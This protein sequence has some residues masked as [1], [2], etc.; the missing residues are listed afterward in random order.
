MRKKPSL[1]Y[2]NSRLVLVIDAGTTNVKV[3]LFDET[4]AVIEK[5]TKKISKKFPAK[6]RV[7]QDPEEI[8]AIVCRLL[9]KIFRKHKEKADKILGVGITNQRETI[10]A[11]DKKTGRAIY[12]A[13][14]WED[15]RGKD[16]L[17]GIRKKI[18]SLKMKSLTGLDIIPY[19]SASKIKWLLENVPRAG[20]LLQENRLACGTMDSWILFKLTGKTSYFT[21][22]TNA[23][24]TMLFNIKTLKWDQE[25]LN[26]F[27]VS[28]GILPDAKP[29]FFPFGKISKN[30]L[31]KELPILAAIGDQQASLY[32]AG[33]SPG[34]T[35]ITYGTGAFILENIG[36]KF[37]TK[38]NLFT[39]LAA[40]PGGRPAFAL[41]GKVS[42]CGAL[43]SPVL[44]N[45]EKKKAAIKKITKQVDRLLKKF[46]KR[47]KKIIIDG[48]VSQADETLEE[49]AKISKVRLERQKNFEGT[50][51]GTAKL[52]FDSLGRIS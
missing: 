10:V 7:E 9:K 12:P 2:S 52:I 26:I 18:S 16:I 21:D 40:G 39:T 25:L 27:G 35:K 48:G 14:V 38:K 20:K 6:G 11:W 28:A 47:C 1:K 36:K 31:G 37:E 45:N 5:M 51:L 13:I 46:P 50:A 15:E 19:F 30:I 43:V 24:R 44:E 29:S 8:F 34:T 33:S 17:A 22:Y 32:A 49:Q 41:E 23:S 3:F 4:L 42:P